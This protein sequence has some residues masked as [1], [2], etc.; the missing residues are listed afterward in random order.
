[1][2]KFWGTFF[3]TVGAGTILALILAVGTVAVIGGM[4]SVEDTPEHSDAIVVLGGGFFRP[5]HAATLYKQGIA[6]QVWVS[7]PKPGK[8][9]PLL[10]S[11]GVKILPQEE[12]YRRLLV[13][14]GV[15]NNA[16]HF[17]GHRLA[18]TKAEAHTFNN[19][20]P[21]ADSIVLVTSPY[22]VMRAKLIFSNELPG[23]R[24]LA[25]GTPHEPFRKQW[26]TDRTSAVSVVMEVAK[27]VWYGIGGS[28]G[29]EP[30]H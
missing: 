19:A 30:T 2:K 18:N 5:L 23:R 9:T 27:L 21:N 12:I 15:P 4:L 17:F 29:D 20:A 26:W 1:M 22:H 8:A 14:H 10:K 13:K 6:P 3:K 7:R 28:F 25:V 24:I 16:I 11:V